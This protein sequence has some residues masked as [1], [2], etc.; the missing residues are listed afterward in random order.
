MVKLTDLLILL[1]AVTFVVG[2]VLKLLEIELLGMIPIAY[3]RF[4]VACLTFSIAL[5]LR[6]LAKK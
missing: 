6:D 4:A 3:W 5:S 1:A 2:V